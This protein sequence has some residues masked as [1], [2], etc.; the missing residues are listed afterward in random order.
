MKILKKITCFIFA[1]LLMYTNILAAVVSDNDGS[2]FIT[3]AEFDSLKNNFQNQIDSYNTSIDSKIDSAISSYLAGIKVEKET[4]INPLVSNY[5]DI[6]W[7]NDMYMKSAT[8]EYS[9]YN[10]YTDTTYAWRIPTFTTYRVLRAGRYLFSGIDYRDIE[11]RTFSFNFNTNTLQFI[12]DDGWF[13]SGE[14]RS[15]SVAPFGPLVLLTKPDT[16]API[17]NTSSNLLQYEAIMVDRAYPCVVRY[18][19]G[20]IGDPFYQYFKG[21]QRVSTGDGA[22]EIAKE[23][24]DIIAFKLKWHNQNSWG[25]SIGTT[26]YES[27]IFRIK[28]SESGY[29]TA[30]LSSPRIN[31][32][33]GNPWPNNAL[34]TFNKHLICNS[35]FS[36]DQYNV[37]VDTLKV[38]FLG[39]NTNTKVNCAVENKNRRFSD[40]T[41]YDFSDSEMGS[42]KSNITESGVYVNRHGQNYGDIF[43]FINNSGTAIE[44]RLSLPLW[45]QY[46]L[47]SLINPDFKVDGSGLQIGGGIP[48]AKN[49]LKKGTLTVTLKY[50][51]AN[52]DL[53]ISDT[54][55]QDIYLSF[56]KADF[57]DASD[58][59]YRDKDGN[60]L[61]D[62][63]L[64]PT[65]TDTTYKVDIPVDIGDNVWFRMGPKERGASG[66]YS[67]INDMDVKL[68]QE[69][70]T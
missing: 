40:W 60:S 55:S 20:T 24:D 54:P 62:K 14:G 27:N 52:D 2:A 37:D 3:K 8:R 46:D 56:K 7:K 65:T 22:V 17:L 1:L 57:L 18:E 38:M 10:T 59:Y 42:F 28:K 51:V 25:G 35:F 45:P 53:S 67:K 33:P 39:N 48:I 61:K 5:K 69:D 16:K 15:G 63:L 12:P 13:P 41:E 68:V 29:G 9:N 70:N 26:Q 31:S 49:I 19:G 66:L 34:G 30:N 21:Y 58:N 47:K 36:T 44:P 50:T 43:N 64:E 6:K 32:F 4:I 23:S 11:Q